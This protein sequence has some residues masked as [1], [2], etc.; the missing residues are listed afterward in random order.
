MQTRLRYLLTVLAISAALVV[1]VRCK[2]AAKRVGIDALQKPVDFPKDSVQPNEP[3]ALD[4]KV[5]YL[6]ENPETFVVLRGF[7]DAGSS[8][9]AAS[10]LLAV[11]R[12]VWA[13]AYLMERG[14][15]ARHM[16]IAT[17]LHGRRCAQR[18]G[19]CNTITFAVA[20][21][22]GALNTHDFPD[23]EFML[24]HDLQW[25]IGNTS[26]KIIV[27]AGFVTDLASIP[28]PIDEFLH[29]NG[30]YNRAAVIHDWLYW[31]QPCTRK[32]SDMLLYRA[33]H[34]S[35]VSSTR[36]RLIYYGVRTQPGQRAWEGDAEDR[37]RGNIAVV[38]EA[39]RQIAD[40]NMPWAAYRQAL[41]DVGIADGVIFPTDS[42]FCK[43][44]MA[45]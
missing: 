11:T 24:L 33:M 38:P 9:V 32:Q 18:K 45:P 44:G 1:L 40:Q 43:Q 39:F 21:P 22:P 15:D 26:D 14:V 12:S 19:D 4:D 16:S 10:T 3:S 34:E 20:K 8:D 29:K 42:G 31:I 5:I 6:E 36:A 25:E 35:A 37:R 30:A 41:H 7:T 13:K 2:E 28:P 27:P 17:A 23:E